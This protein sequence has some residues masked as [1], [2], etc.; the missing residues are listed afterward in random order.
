MNKE[1]E[2]KEIPEVKFNFGTN[3][4]SEGELKKQIQELIEK[5]NKAL[6]EAGYIIKEDGT[7]EKG[8]KLRQR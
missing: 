5:R 2:K 1:Y 4:K 3:G 6:I 7:V 8:E